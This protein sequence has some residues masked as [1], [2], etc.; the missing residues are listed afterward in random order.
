MLI[1]C[2]IYL[3]GHVVLKNFP[4]VH[5]EPAAAEDEEAEDE[6]EAS[7]VP[8]AH[9]DDEDEGSA[10]KKRSRASPEPEEDSSSSGNDAPLN[11]APLRSIPPKTTVAKKRCVNPQ[12]AGFLPTVIS[13][14]G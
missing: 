3:Q 9:S 6:D 4:P 12:W 7:S 11:V 1:N 13:S 10:T 14:D 5:E 2:S 8:A